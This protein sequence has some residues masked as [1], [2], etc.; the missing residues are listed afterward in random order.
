MNKKVLGLNIFAILLI[1]SMP[2][3]SSIQAQFYTNVSKTDLLD[4]PQWSKD[5]AS[6]V[7]FYPSEFY[8]REENSKIIIEGKVGET[9]SCVL[10]SGF[11]MVIWEGLSQF[12]FKLLPKYLG[13]ASLISIFFYGLIQII[14]GPGVFYYS[15]GDQFEIH[16]D[17]MSEVYCYPE[18]PN[19]PYIFKCEGKGV[20][21]Y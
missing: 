14:P 11:R 10:L 6:L 1:L 19:I 8:I 21:A 3:V 5:K 7:V 15:P 16:L 2:Y 13:V 12:L 20:E 18:P 17:E 4:S 9:G